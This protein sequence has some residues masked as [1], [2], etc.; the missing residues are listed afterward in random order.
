MSNRLA[1]GLALTAVGATLV[2]TSI[3]SAAVAHSSIWRLP[4]QDQ[5]NQTDEPESNAQ[6]PPPPGGPLPGGPRVF[7]PPKGATAKPSAHGGTMYTAK[8][9]TEFHTGKAGNLTTLKTKSG[10]TAHF[11]ANGKVAS[12]H[13][14]NMTINH[15]AVGG[16][17]VSARLAGGGRVVSYGGHRGFVERPF[18]RGGRAYMRRSYFYGGRRWAA[19]YRGNYWGGRV[20]YTY[21]PG[22]YWA[23]DFYGWAYNP[24]AAPVAWGWGWGGAPWYGYYG[25]Y[26][27]PYPEY[28]SPVHLLTDYLLAEN[29]R[30][31]YDA[32]PAAAAAPPPAEES[33]PPP[34]ADQNAVTV[35]PEVK[36]AIAEEVRAQIAAE[37]A[38]AAA[39][40]ATAPV[41][42]T[43]AAAA[44]DAAPSATPTNSQL[45]E[46][47]NPK[48]RTFVVS[49]TLAEQTDDGTACSL[50]SGDVL[51][52]IGDTPDA[53]QNVKVLV[54]S[55][56]KGDCA[57]G[58]QISVSVQDLQDMH[59][60][61]HQKIDAGLQSLADDQ[62]KKGMPASPAPGRRTVPEGTAQPD[63]DAESQ[64]DQMDQNADKAEADVTQSQETAQ[65]VN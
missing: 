3:A 16:R 56:Q 23:A 18:Y 63:A 39:P 33:A 9:G 5:T 13:S 43:A 7:T 8:N 26:F 31:A 15:G 40:N 12:I 54:T 57:T 6:E 24:W 4:N 14:G 46:A 20:Y 1:M 17:M 41:P 47:L 44:A 10:A 58:T 30:A 29:L 2:L 19:V 55:S 36:Q 27:A 28:A 48:E 21:V 53:N 34:A 11:G 32:R 49:N 59:N 61:F 42:A 37:Q 45:P 62:G 25:Y 50:S 22:F 51:T 38:A 52:R 35:T 65:G 60:D 64:L